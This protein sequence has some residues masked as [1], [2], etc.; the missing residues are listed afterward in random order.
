MIFVRLIRCV[1]ASFVL[2][3][4]LPVAALTPEQIGKLA[5]SDSDARNEALNS[6]AAAGDESAIAFLSALA[7]GNVQ[8]SASAKKVLIVTDGKGV[9]AVTGK[10]V[11]KLPEDL[12]EVVANNVFR[13]E[14]AAAI[15]TLKLTSADRA[16]RLA[17]AKTM[18]DETEGD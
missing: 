2:A 10:P 14:L 17:A 4:S 13:R 6:I 12:D 9:D 18:Q 15:A 1:L 7:E 5:S 8:A 11:E 16:V 3:A